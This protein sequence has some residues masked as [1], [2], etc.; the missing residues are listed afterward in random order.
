MS[1]CTF[2]GHRDCPETVKPALRAAIEEHIKMGVDSFYVGNNGRFDAYV[3]GI[4]QQLKT[5]YPHIHYGVVISSLPIGGSSRYD[6][7]DTMYPEG[8]EEG[9]PKFAI[10][11]RN[12]WMVNKADYV[13]CYVRYSWGGAYKFSQLA[14]RQGKQV[15]NLHKESRV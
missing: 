4:L 11:R 13:I 9:P 6:S 3:H 1:A 12:R 10:D 2:F 7:E 15:L 5:I 8:L 14:K